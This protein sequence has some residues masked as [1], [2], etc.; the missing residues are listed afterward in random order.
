MSVWSGVLDSCPGL[1]CCVVNIK[2]RLIY[3]THGYKAIAARL[4]GHKCEE[5]RNYPPLISAMDREIH[6]AL[7]AACLGETNAIEFAEGT[8]QQNIWD[9]T[10]SPLRLV[11]DGESKISGVVIR[12]VSSMST[13]QTQAPVI[14]S[15][16]N[17]LEAVP[18][19]ACVTDS[20]GVI[21]AANKF[22]SSS[23]G[24]DPSGSSIAEILEPDVHSEL[25]HIITK[26]SGSAEGIMQDTSPHENFFQFTPEEVYLDAALNDIPAK[27]ETE[28]RRIR[29][30][31]SPIDWNGQEST[32]LTFEDITETKRTSEQ[33]RKLLT[34]DTRTGIL[35]R[36]GLEHILIRKISTAVRESQELSL[37]ALAPDN[38]KQVTE[39]SGYV[40]GERMIRNFVWTV[41]DFI[42]G[43]AE[44]MAAR[45]S[46]DEF[47]I[48][49]HCS[50]AVAVV[51]ANEI[52]ARADGVPVSAG[53]A[54]FS[55]GM[56][57]GVNEFMG[58]AYDAM[59]RARSEGGNI[60]VLA[61]R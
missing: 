20:K 29:L 42:S 23:L 14:R 8:N 38:L 18:F 34:F 9:L 36:R 43:R 25:L 48:I 60:T 13:G 55:D 45:Y 49:A 35:N 44:S 39:N 59:I 50:G 26:R 41:K 3:A 46:R 19:R 58:A 17:I 6:D 11:D 61:G 15:N 30:H 32:M 40:A 21:L 12:I 10:A 31:A 53:V 22:L 33:L 47:M 28:S 5:G 24:V 16:P 1:L 56:Y 37:I 51:M 54:D 4:F 2:G 27:K 57:S 52:R 7:T